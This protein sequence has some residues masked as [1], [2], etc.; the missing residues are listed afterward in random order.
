MR[1]TI[2]LIIAT[3]IWGCWAPEMAEPQEASNPL[4]AVQEGHPEHH[5]PPTQSVELT[6]TPP[7]QFPTPPF[8]AW[9]VEDRI[10]IEPPGA[11]AIPIRRLGV[12]IEVLQIMNEGQGRMLIE[13]GTCGPDGHTPVRGY[14]Q[15]DKGIRTKGSPGSAQDPLARALSQRA[16]WA[17]QQDLPNQAEHHDMCA[18]VDHGF[19]L[20]TDRQH[21]QWQLDGGQMDLYFSENQWTL[22]SETLSPP[23]PNQSGRCRT[24]GRTR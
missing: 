9:T 16:R 3:N 20:S 2:T 1:A 22:D 14:L 19:T 17:N 18:L 21:A 15:I 23:S 7:E 11:D 12:R 6:A 8:T 5:L 10:S 13:C 4:E 24:S